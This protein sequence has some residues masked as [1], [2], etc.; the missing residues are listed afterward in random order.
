VTVAEE[1]LQPADARDFQLVDTDIGVNQA[2]G[3]ALASLGA[4]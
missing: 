3:T 1:Q 4:G 2:Q